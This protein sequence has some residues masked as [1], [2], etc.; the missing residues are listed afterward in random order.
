MSLPETDPLHLA[1]PSLAACDAVVLASGPEGIVLDRTVFYAR[2]GG[3]PGDTGALVWPDGTSTSI[4]DTIK[5]EPP[6]L[7]L[8]VPAG[9][10]PLPVPGTPV[11]ARLDWPGRHLRMRTHTLL[12]L[13]CSLLPGAGVTGGQ[14]GEGKGRLDFD[15]A[16]AP[17]KAALEAGLAALIEADHPITT[18]WITAAELEANPT[19]VRTLSVRPP[20]GSGRVRLVRIGSG[21][22]PVDLQPCGGTHVAST[23]EIGSV[24]VAKIENKGRNN[25]RVSLVLAQ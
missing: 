18:E 8:H 12:H 23:A 13:L 25:R 2:G 10:S 7:A 19:L 3:Q 20:I 14:I 16:A 21:P 11:L 24:Q 4:A 5:G 15:L 9:G 17:D 22:V 6:G 1:D